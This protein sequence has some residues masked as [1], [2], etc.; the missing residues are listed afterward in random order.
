MY[1]DFV[2][3][4]L[5]IASRDIGALILWDIFIVRMHVCIFVIPIQFITETRKVQ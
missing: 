3:I 4:Q 2:T 1:K 5:L